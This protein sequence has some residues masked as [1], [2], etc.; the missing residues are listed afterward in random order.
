MA[1]VHCSA[2]LQCYDN[3]YLGRLTDLGKLKN[4]IHKI[5][6]CKHKRIKTLIVKHYK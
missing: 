1:A 3:F 6:K 4:T 5:G 2:E